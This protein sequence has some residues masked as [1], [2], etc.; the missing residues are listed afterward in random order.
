M[1][2]S[3]HHHYNNGSVAETAAALEWMDL[4]E[5]YNPSLQPTI[6]GGTGYFQNQSGYCNINEFLC[7]LSAEPLGSKTANHK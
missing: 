1:G 5:V 3:F 7:K 2:I 4:S 6:Q